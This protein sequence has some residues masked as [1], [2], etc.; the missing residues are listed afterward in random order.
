MRGRGQLSDEMNWHDANPWSLQT[1]ATC[2]LASEQAVIHPG[3]PQHISVRSRHA[4]Y[5]GDSH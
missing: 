3:A 2:S 1:G 5:L 4:Q